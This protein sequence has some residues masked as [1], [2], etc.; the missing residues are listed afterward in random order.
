L[1]VDATQTL[2]A[3]PFPMAEIRPDFLVAAG[4]KWLL[5]PYGFSLLYVSEKWRAS[6]PL[7]ESWLAR[8][9]AQD[10]A[11]LVNY[12]DIYLPGARRFDVGEKCTPTLL[13]GA[14]A[15]LR[16]IK[17]WGIAEIAHSLAVINRTIA[18][19]LEQL[20]FKVP[21]ESER[22]PHMFG[23]LLPQKF[24][25]NL[26]NELKREKIYISQRGHA[27]RFA[28]HLHTHDEDVERLRGALR[29]L[30]R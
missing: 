19:E 27:L 28:P 4:Y 9:N 21:D 10:F 8:L 18:H 2:G 30:L 1:V 24:N 23:A 26:V 12:S 14:I 6:R 5:G 11:S 3:V 16:Q 20:G 22:C 25:G 29:K 7:E 13:P 17:A 15:A